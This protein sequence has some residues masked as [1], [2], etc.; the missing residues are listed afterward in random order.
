M[1]NKGLSKEDSLAI[2]GVAICFMLVHHLFY[3]SEVLNE[4]NVKF[5]V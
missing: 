4:M 2:K 5:F 1:I 3:K